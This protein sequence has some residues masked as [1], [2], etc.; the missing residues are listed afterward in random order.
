MFKLFGWPT[1]ILFFI[2]SCNKKT[3]NVSQNPVASV[4]VN[5]TVFPNDPIN[6]KV[7]TIGGWMYMDG[8][9]HGIVLYRLSNE[10]FLAFER[11]STHLPNNANAK[12]FVQKDN[13]TLRDTISGSEWRL[14]DGIVTKG[15]AEW[16]LRQY[17]TT[18]DGNILKIIN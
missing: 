10:Q 12:A 18:Y 17:G 9:I 3:Q 13:F 1:F 14:I 6:F 15:P 2:L 7:Q 4:P 8:G 16:G 11:S 5:I